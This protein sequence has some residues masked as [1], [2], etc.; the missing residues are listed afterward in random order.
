MKSFAEKLRETRENLGLTQKKLSEMVEVSSKIITSYEKGTSKPR[1][2][3]ARKLA[4]VLGVSY[5]YL[6]NDAIE[7]PQYGIEKDPFVEETFER[8]GSRAAREANHLLESN[9]AL[10]AGGALDQDEK[11]MF[12]EAVTKAYWAA[13]ESARETYGRKKIT[14]G[15]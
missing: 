5:D 15:R 8:F 13:K 11:D 1:G 2:T 10:F 6:V 7:D 3:T 12:F 4:R 14:G 9:R